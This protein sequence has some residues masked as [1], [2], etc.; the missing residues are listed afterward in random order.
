MRTGCGDHSR[1]LALC[2]LSLGQK[3]GGFSRY[4]AL[5]VFG[6]SFEGVGLLAG[7]GDRGVSLAGGSFFAPQDWKTMDRGILTNEE[8]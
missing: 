2:V 8:G 4:R 6:G 7:N 5:V 1:W 3:F